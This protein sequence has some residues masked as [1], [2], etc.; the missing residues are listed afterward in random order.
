MKVYTLL[1]VLAIASLTSGCATVKDRQAGSMGSEYK[2]LLAMEKQK[3]A[4]ARTIEDE[5]SK[6][7]PEMNADGCE[8]LG[9]QHARQGNVVMALVQYGKALHLNPNNAGVRYKIGCL[10]LQRGLVTEALAE[11]DQILKQEPSNALAHQGKGVAFIATRELDKAQDEFRQALRFNSALW[12]PY[13]CLGIIYDRQKRYSDA[14]SEYEKALAINPRS[15]AVLNDRGMS[16]YMNGEYEKSIQSFTA[17]LQLDPANRKIHNN[18][19][20]ALAGLGRFDESLEAFKKSR[21]EAGAHNNIGYIY[22]TK[23]EYAKAAAAFQEAAEAS[24]TFYAKAQ[25]NIERLEKLARTQQR[26]E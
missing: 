4:A 2:M 15:A 25:E 1:C 18:L 16:C 14:L 11:F 26:A 19:G 21:G 17:A 3:S 9:D 6:K 5:S 23:R 13:A 7:L 8:R 10:L 20:L 22:M 24:P 12:Q